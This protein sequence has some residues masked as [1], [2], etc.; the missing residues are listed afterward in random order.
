MKNKLKRI[1]D[2]TLFWPFM[3]LLLLLLINAFLTKGFF[4]IEWKDGRFSG[5]LVDIL[6]RSTYIGIIAI[7]LTLVISTGGIDISVGSV[8]A[9][10]GAIAAYLIGGELILQGDQQVLVTRTPMGVAITAALLSALILG[11][12]N[13][14]LVSRLRIQPIVATLILMVAGRGIAQLVTN[15]QIITIYY[16]PYY[17]IGNGTFLGIPFSLYILLAVLI[18]VI[19]AT[20]KTAL[21]LFFESIGV[22]R[23]ASRYSGIQEQRIVFWSYAF[24]AFCAGV[25][26]LLVSSNVKSADGNNAGDLF[27][28][29]AILA[30][31]IGG[32]SLNGG[33]FNLAGS[34]LGAVIIQTLTTTIYSIG[35]PPQ[36]N[37]VIKSIVVFLV[38]MLQSENFRA[39]FRFGRK[40]F[41]MRGAL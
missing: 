6:N 20:R 14:F 17:F 2:T 34:I 26:G 39:L 21:G 25:S 33:K 30:V 7:G 8:V 4:S 18:L 27:E 22:N 10:S 1:N 11:M 29:D 28:L 15:G 41:Q 3:V 12:W 19:L 23:T 40:S 38:S 16:K 36:V 31:V 5:I 35:V 9:I 37:L 24:C 13:G 32:T